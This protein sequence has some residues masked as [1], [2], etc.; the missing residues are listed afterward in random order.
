[1]ADRGGPGR[2][3]HCAAVDRA[4]RA[5]RCSEGLGG[6]GRGGQSCRRRS[7]IPIS[8]RSLFGC[9]A[10]RIFRAAISGRSPW[11]RLDVG[12]YAQRH[13]RIRRRP[14]DI[15]PRRLSLVAFYVRE[16]IRLD[17][18][19][20]FSWCRLQPV[21]SRR[22][23]HAVLRRDHLQSLQGYPHHARKISAQTNW[24]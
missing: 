7:R 23:V 13:Q 18:A 12:R 2:R 17:W 1:M 16:L 5:A 21:S 9:A 8:R 11:C 10:Q 22:R 4:G 20:P 24:C 3:R 6:T 19:R 14:C 15:S